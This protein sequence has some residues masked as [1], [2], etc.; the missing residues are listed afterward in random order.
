MKKELKEE[1]VEPTK[2]EKTSGAE[3][4]KEIKAQIAK[5]MRKWNLIGKLAMWSL[6]VFLPYMLIPIF[7]PWILNLEVTYRSSDHKLYRTIRVESVMYPAVFFRSDMSN[8][9]SLAKSHLPLQVLYKD[10]E[11]HS[12]FN[13]IKD[14]IFLC[15]PKPSSKSL[16]GILTSSDML[17]WNFQSADCEEGL[18]H[19]EPGPVVIDDLRGTEAYIN[20][21]VNA[22]YKLINLAKEKIAKD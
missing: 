12:K 16:V 15:T 22:Y 1:G 11:L 20:A 4:E 3:L 10:M 7:L 18:K 9:K 14:E 13:G 2:V 6:I 17:Y 19:R 5:S 8:A 21:W